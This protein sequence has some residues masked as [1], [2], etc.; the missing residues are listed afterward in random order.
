MKTGILRRTSQTLFLP[1]NILFRLV[2]VVFTKDKIYKV[3]ANQ[4][5]ELLIDA[6]FLSDQ[7]RT[8]QTSF[9]QSWDSEK[10]EI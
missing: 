3:S 9:L 1:T 5:Q 6:N 7:K 2:K 8:S 10:I 4:E